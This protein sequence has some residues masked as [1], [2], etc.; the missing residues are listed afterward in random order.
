MCQSCMCATV[1]LLIVV[2]AAIVLI[3]IV[4]SKS[5]SDKTNVLTHTMHLTVTNEDLHSPSPH[6]NTDSM[7]FA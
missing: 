3:P 1:A 4:C 2:L 5:R 6:S 7:C